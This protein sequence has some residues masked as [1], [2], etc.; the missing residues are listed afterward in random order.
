V[1]EAAVV[2]LLPHATPDDV[3]LLYEYLNQHR[4][5]DP[6]VVNAVRERATELESALMDA[7]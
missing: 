5:D 4:R 1:R 6:D 3:T 7:P 2:A